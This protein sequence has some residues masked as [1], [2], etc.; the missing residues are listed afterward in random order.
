MCVKFPLRD[1]NF[2]LYPTHPTNTY[3]CGVTITLRVCG[4]IFMKYIK[5]TMN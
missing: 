1:L 2:G 3:A 4:G 5:Y